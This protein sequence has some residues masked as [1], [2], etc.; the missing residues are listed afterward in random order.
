[1]MLQDELK[2]PPASLNG[3][4]VATIQIFLDFI[5]FS[6][7]PRLVIIM[8]CCITFNGNSNTIMSLMYILIQVLDHNADSYPLDINVS[9]IFYA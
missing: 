1:M 6:T 7:W 3:R 8:M 5:P 2:N 9:V 4:Y